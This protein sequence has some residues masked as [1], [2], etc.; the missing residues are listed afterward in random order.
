MAGAFDSSDKNIH[1]AEGLVN[2]WNIVEIENV[3]CS[4]T[5]MEDPQKIWV[6]YEE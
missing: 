5:F 1:C 3:T 4:I 2:M 6:C